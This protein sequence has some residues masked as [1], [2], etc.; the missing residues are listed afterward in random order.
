MSSPNARRGFITAG[1]SR[2]RHYESW[3]SKS[4]IN[5]VPL[6][7]PQGCTPETVG[8]LYDSQDPAEL[9]Q[10]MLEVRLANGVAINAGWYPEGDPQGS[11]RVAVRREGRLLVPPSKWSSACETAEEVEQL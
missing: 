11:Y 3:E 6:H 8:F 4:M 9:G 1:P 5:K 10:D 7:L 2:H